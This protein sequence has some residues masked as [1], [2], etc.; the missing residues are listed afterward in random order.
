MDLWQAGRQLAEELIAEATFSDSPNEKVVSAAFVSEDYEGN[1]LPGAFLEDGPAN[2]ALPFARVQPVSAERDPDAPGRY[3]G[4][5]RVFVVAGGGGVAG[6]AGTNDSHGINQETGANRDA[7]SGQGKRKGR[8]TDEI[9]SRLLE[10]LGVP[11]APGQLTQSAHGFQGEVT[12]LGP[13]IAVDGVQIVARSFDV[14]VYNL[15]ASRTYASVS[16]LAGAHAGGG[17]VNLSWRA[18]APR[19]DYFDIVV[20]RGTNPGDAAPTAPSGAGSGTAVPVTSTT[21]AQATGLA[22]GQ[23]YNFAVFVRYAEVAG[24][25]ASDR[26]SASVTL[27]VA[28]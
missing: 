17:V 15:T 2:F 26:T 23:T 22:T 8:S 16:G 9:V 4:T 27:A 18:L 7:V 6:A 21:A 20:R 24:A 1:F 13:R 28:T 5:L 19:F 10:V 11:G 3:V 25:T 14:K 12:Q